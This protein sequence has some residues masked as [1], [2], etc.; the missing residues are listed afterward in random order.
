MVVVLLDICLH[1]RLCY[2]E[3]EASLQRSSWQQGEW[4]YSDVTHSLHLR[5]YL[6]DSLKG[7]FLRK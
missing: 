7:Q 1:Q 6:G 5:E 2:S 4:R 3:Y